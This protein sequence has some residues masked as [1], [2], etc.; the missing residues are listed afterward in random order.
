MYVY[1]KYICKENIKIQKSALERLI[2]ELSVDVDPRG[3]LHG[4][5]PK[6]EK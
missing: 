2:P 3:I 4:I 1:V 6:Q 5:L